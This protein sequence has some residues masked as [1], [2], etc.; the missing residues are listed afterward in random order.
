MKLIYKLYA[1]ALH[2]AIEKGNAQIVQL[3][4]QRP[5][6]DV[7][8]TLVLNIDFF[9]PFNDLIIFIIFRIFFV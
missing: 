5:D 3:L 8:K 6:I 1:T 2:D 4:L 9:I 7:N